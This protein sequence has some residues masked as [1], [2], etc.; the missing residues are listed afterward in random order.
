M[1]LALE[2]HLVSRGETG[3]V[4]E[5]I[6]DIGRDASVPRARVSAG[7]R[8]YQSV[9]AVRSTA[10]GFNLAAVIRWLDEEGGAE[11]LGKLL[12]TR[13]TLVHTL[14]FVIPDD[15]GACDAAWGLVR[16]VLD[17]SPVHRVVAL[18]VEGSWMDMAGRVDMRARR[19][20]GRSTSAAPSWPG[21]IRRRGCASAPVTPL[22]TWGGP[23][24]QRPP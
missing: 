6:S 8:T 12:G 19:T 11:A 18:L 3:R 22:S 2:P 13:H 15:V 21:A 9:E 7:F 14:G 24:R 20:S 23:A 16:A 17:G 5:T 4:V 10:R 1:R